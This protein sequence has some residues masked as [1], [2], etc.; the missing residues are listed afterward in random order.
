MLVTKSI[1]SRGLRDDASCVVLLPAGGGRPRGL[2]KE[3]RDLG[4]LRGGMKLRTGSGSGTASPTSLRS[5]SPPPG[6]DGPSSEKRR[7]SLF[8][9]RRA[10]AAPPAAAPSGTCA[11]VFGDRPSPSPLRDPHLSYWTMLRSHQLRG[12]RTRFCPRHPHPPS[13]H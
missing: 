3:S 12:R 13:H 9:R 4:G 6:G 2:E 1:E 7:G 5:A 8:G 11:R 10:A